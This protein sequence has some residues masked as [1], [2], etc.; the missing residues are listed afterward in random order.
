MLTRR[1]MTVVVVAG[2]GITA[3]LVAASDAT[4]PAGNAVPGG[5]ASALVGEHSR[6]RALS[7]ASTLVGE[8]FRRRALSSARTLV[9]AHCGI[10]GRT[11]K[12]T[13]TDEGG[14]PMVMATGLKQP[15]WGNRVPARRYR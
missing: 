14:T 10:S 2:G 4:G 8:H 6:R 5:Q 15:S 11:R 13:I 12:R 1:P 3:P 7:S 9:G